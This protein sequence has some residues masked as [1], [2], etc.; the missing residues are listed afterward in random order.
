MRKWLLRAQELKCCG[1]YGKEESPIHAKEILKA[2][3]LRLFYQLNEAAGSP[4]QGLAENMAKGFDLM[5]PIPTGG[6]FPQKFQHTTLT[7]HKSG[8]WLTFPSMPFGGR[9]ENARTRIL[10]KTSIESPLRSA[11]EAG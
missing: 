5:G 8:K 10:Q 6:I 4:D 3:D 2:K 9:L 1:Q 7:Q 11:T